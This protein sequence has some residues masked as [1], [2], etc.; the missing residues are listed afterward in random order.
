MFEFPYEEDE[1]APAP[2]PVEV[3]LIKYVCWEEP[4]IPAVEESALVEEGP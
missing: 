4:P 1:A 2:V 3:A